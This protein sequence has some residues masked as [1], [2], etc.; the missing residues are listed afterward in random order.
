MPTTITAAMLRM[1]RG[2]GRH[3]VSGE[4]T[5]RSYDGRKL[6]YFKVC[7]STREMSRMAI[8]LE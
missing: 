4:E 7:S 2:L 5:L 8:F 3:L 6:P 1:G